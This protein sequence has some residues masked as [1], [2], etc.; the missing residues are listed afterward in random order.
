MFKKKKGGG[1]QKRGSNIGSCPQVP[2]NIPGKQNVVDIWPQGLLPL[3]W[4][5]I[6]EIKSVKFFRQIHKARAS[7]R[8]SYLFI[9]SFYLKSG[10]SDET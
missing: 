9:P 10:S 5:C 2:V 4:V 1:Q 6:L 7:V 8:Y 3:T